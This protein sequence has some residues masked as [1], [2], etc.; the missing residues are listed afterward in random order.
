MKKT[1]P[2]MKTKTT[3]RK[4]GKMKNPRI[5]KKQKKKH[6]AERKKA[7]SKKKKQQ[8]TKKCRKTKGA[9]PIQRTY[10]NATAARY[11]HYRTATF[12]ILRCNLPTIPLGRRHPVEDA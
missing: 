6:K 4:T 2:K 7:K 3:K 11:L 12:C 9:A 8:R 10:Y 5:K 1:K